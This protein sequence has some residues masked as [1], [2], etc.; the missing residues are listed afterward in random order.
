[1]NTTK[2]MIQEK[3]VAVCDILGFS[4][5]V[6]RYTLQEIVNN[7]LSYLRK[8]LYFSINEKPPPP[9]PPSFK[10]LKEQ[11]KVGIAW[12]SDTILL[13]SLSN[14]DEHCR[15]VIKTVAWLLFSTMSTPETRIRAGISYGFVHI[16]EKN[17]IYVGHP[18]INAFLL[19]KDQ[20]WCGGCLDDQAEERIP[21]EVKINNTYDWYL[22]QYYVPLKSSQ[23]K[24]P[25]LKFAIDWTRGLHNMKTFNWS[26]TSNEPFPKEIQTRSDEISKWR[27]TKQFHDSVCKRCNIQ[28]SGQEDLTQQK[29]RN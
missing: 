15:Q 23:G 9:N 18:I 24:N 29:I 4:K 27:N 22:T 11:N 28:S 17:E 6:E 8:A 26:N 3:M 13:Y 20:I 19:E 2:N 1:M 5:T 10:D 7:S 21:K 14:E 25:K 16:D 12:F